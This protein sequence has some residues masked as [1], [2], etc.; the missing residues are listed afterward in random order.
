[1]DE[2]LNAY[3]AAGQLAPVLMFLIVAGIFAAVRHSERIKPAKVRR[4]G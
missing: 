1:M 3:F 2:L 4:D